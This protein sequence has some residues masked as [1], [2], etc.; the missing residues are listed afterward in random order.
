[1]LAFFFEPQKFDVKGRLL[2][3]AGRKRLRKMNDAVFRKINS[4]VCYTIG[5]KFR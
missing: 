1:M 2:D 3:V 5:E 4:S